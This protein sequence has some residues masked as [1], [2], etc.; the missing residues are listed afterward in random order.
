MIDHPFWSDYGKCFRRDLAILRGPPTWRRVALTYAYVVIFVMLCLTVDMV[1][2]DHV[3]LQ[4]VVWFDAVV[5]AI[6]NGVAFLARSKSSLLG[7]SP[8]PG[9]DLG[10]RVAAE[11]AK[12]RQKFTASAWSRKAG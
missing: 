10:D 9:E 2:V 8:T 6:T 12:W 4:N 1:R 3:L 5:L 7:A 11:R